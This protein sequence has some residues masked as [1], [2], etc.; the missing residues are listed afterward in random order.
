MTHTPR[1]TLRTT[2]DGSRTLYSERYFETFHSHKGALTESKHVFL[3]GTGVAERLQRSYEVNLLEVGFGTGL[4]FFLTADVAL[5]HGADLRYVA[6]EKDLLSAE[7]F[8]SLEY[9]K[10]L[11]RPDLFETFLAWRRLDQPDF[12]V[13]GVRL[14]LLLGDATQQRLPENRFHAVYQ[15]AFSPDVNPELWSEAFLERLRKSL[16]GDGV[17]STYCVKGE[18]RRRM[19]ALG[20]EVEKRAGPPGGK[21]EMLVARKGIW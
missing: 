6:L 4:N 13:E 16:A 21:R 11:E 1:L 8:A 15:D 3:E 5:K 19:Q 17:L 10:Y 18:V 7:A 2:G 14:D 12:E 9:G 20:F